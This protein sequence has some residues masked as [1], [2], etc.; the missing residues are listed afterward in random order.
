MVQS[1]WKIAKLLT[2]NLNIHLPYDSTILLLDMYSRERK[3]SSHKH[4]HVNV[5]TGSIYNCQNYEATQ[6]SIKEEKDK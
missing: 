1:P 4:K 6:I 5:Y 3:E 2:I